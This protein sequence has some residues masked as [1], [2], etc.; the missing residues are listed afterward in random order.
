[1]ELSE[2][3]TRRVEE[4]NKYCQQSINRNNKLRGKM[5]QRETVITQEDSTQHFG[6]S[7]ILIE[8]GEN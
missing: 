2:N 8:W 1:M 5:D 3:L 7:E 4:M 6:T